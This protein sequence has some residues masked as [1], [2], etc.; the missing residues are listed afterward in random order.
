MLQGLEVDVFVPRVQ[1]VSPTELRLTI[2]MDAPEL[3]QPFVIS[4]PLSTSHAWCVT[5][6]TMT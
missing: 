1:G 3:S 4:Y 5:L 6:M 2:E